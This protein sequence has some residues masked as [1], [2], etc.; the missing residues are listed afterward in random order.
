MELLQQGAPDLN[1]QDWDSPQL[2]EERED[3]M[4]VKED[5]SLEDADLAF[6]TSILESFSKPKSEAVKH[7]TRRHSTE[8]FCAVFPPKGALTPTDPK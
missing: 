6:I 2:L 5:D 3:L 4:D 8:S 7:D 1:S